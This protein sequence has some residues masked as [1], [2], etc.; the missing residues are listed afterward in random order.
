ME[1]PGFWRKIKFKSFMVQM[2]MP[3]CSIISTQQLAFPP[4]F[5][6][7]TECNGST[8]GA[9]KWT[10]VKLHELQR[11][12][13][14]TSGDSNRLGA[15]CTHAQTRFIGLLLFFNALF[16]KRCDFI[17]LSRLHQLHWLFPAKICRSQ[18]TQSSNCS[19]K[20]HLHHFHPVAPSFD[21]TQ[22]FR[23]VLRVFHNFR[24]KTRA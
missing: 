5:A 13:H 22:G 14:R 15:K 21:H 12:L 16:A 4:C 11:D 17:E 18:A 23:V 10:S 20:Y 6:C 9:S 8:P 2:S 3:L 7:A 19:P 24:L 1:I